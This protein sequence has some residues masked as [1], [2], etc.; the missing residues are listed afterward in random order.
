MKTGNK[1]KKA[2]T[3]GPGGKRPGSGRPRLEPGEESVIVAGRVP[4]S[5]R[6]RVDLARGDRTVAEALREALEAWCDQAGA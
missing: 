4:Q 3:P 2:Q 5:L 6:D 1:S